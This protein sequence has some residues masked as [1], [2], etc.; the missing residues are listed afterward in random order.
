MMGPTKWRPWLRSFEKNGD[1]YGRVQLP[2]SLAMLTGQD[3]LALEAIA[4]CWFLYFR[5]DDDG[6]AAALA[7]VRALLPGMQAKC[8]PFARELIAFAGDW[9]DRELLWPLVQP[10][11]S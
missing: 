8:R 2:G 9:S 6:R 4:A 11:T 5:S 3:A 7:A 1:P 10:L